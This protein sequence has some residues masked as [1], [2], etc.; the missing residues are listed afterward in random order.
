MKKRKWRFIR[1]IWNDK[2]DTMMWLVI[3]GLFVYSRITDTD[4]SP[5]LFVVF[6][7]VYYFMYRKTTFWQQSWK[8]KNYLKKI[9]IDSDSII[10]NTD[11]I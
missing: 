4:V 9:G 5:F 1:C 7:Y 8:M 6:F 11:D 10:N 3:A 2:V